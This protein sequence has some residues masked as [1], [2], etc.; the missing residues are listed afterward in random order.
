MLLLFFSFG[1]KRVLV[2]VVVVVDDD[3]DVGLSLIQKCNYTRASSRLRWC[4]VVLLHDKQSA[5]CAVCDGFSAT[6][7]STGA[8]E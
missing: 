1:V 6:A 7:A 2:V 8:Y 5:G 4:F 3:D